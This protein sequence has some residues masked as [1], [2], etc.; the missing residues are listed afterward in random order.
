ML[1]K[2]GV[3]S[4]EQECHWKNKKL[5]FIYMT[6]VRT[7]WKI[8]LVCILISF[9]SRKVGKFIAI[10]Q[11]CKKEVYTFFCYRNPHFTIFYW[12]SY[13]GSFCFSKYFTIMG[14]L[15]RGKLNRVAG[16]SFKPKIS[17]NNT[18]YTKLQVFYEIW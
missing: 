5:K 8:L 12:R 14:I 15:I 7:F 3:H 18:V 2:T 11:L 1:C 10:I 4:Q 9:H 13:M 16:F 17:S 6:C